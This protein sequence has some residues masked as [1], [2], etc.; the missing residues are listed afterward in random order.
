MS[1]S[2]RRAVRGIILRI[3][4]GVLLA[5]LIVELG[6][7]LAGWGGIVEFIPSEQWGYL[8]RPSQ[9]VHSYGVS[10]VINSL[11]LRGPETSARKAA[12]VTRVLFVGDSVTY[13]GGHIKESDLSC[14]AF[15]SL[16]RR[17][18]LNVEAVNLSAPGWSPQNWMGWI[19]A[20]GLLDADAVVVILPE[21]D[22]A[23]PFSTM[24]TFEFFEH[25][26][27]LRIVSMFM[28]FDRTKRERDEITV[29]QRRLTANANVEA[30]C[31]LKRRCEAASVPFLVVFVP[32]HV[33][34]NLHRHFWSLFESN[35]SHDALD[36][37]AV[38][39]PEYFLPDHI[40]LNPA[41]HR[42]TAE[43]TSG[44]IVP[45]LEQIDISQKK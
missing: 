9:S 25:A 11:G 26:P 20:N 23:R 32:S 34:N 10:V 3:A 7:R 45:L 29:E 28:R 40:H 37:R 12:G 35:L 38:L 33:E 8:M 13:G 14:R 43:R 41:G 31:R 36:L 2:K 15:E 22:L 30:L 18:G 42:L 19:S 44:T 27:A 4:F 5:L 24:A 21:V 6:A 17:N 1:A 16:A 39:T